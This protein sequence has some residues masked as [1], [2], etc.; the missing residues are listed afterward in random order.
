M[1]AHSFLVY[2]LYNHNKMILWLI[3]LAFT[4]EVTLMV[5]CL[6]VVLPKMTFTPD[7]LVAHAPGLFI[8]YW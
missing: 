3:I 6:S 4:A 7:C 5:V 1:S 2:V 8:I